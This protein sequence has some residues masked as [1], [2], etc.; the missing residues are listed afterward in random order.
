MGKNL[1][2]Q[3]RGKGGPR[4]R[5]PSFRFL[6]E[7]RYPGTLQTLN[8]KIISIEDCPGHS[9]PLVRVAYA[10][11]TEALQIAP[12]GIK[13]NDDLV[14]NAPEVKHGHVLKLGDVPEGT[15]VYNVENVPGDGGRFVRSSG[16]F[17]RIVAKTEL[18]VTL[19]LPSKKERLFNPRCRATVGIVAGGG[20]VE[21]PF[22]KAGNKHHAMV[23]RNRM[24]PQVKGQ[25]MNAVDHPHGGKRSSK[26]NA[27]TIARRHAP[28]G[29]KVGMLAPRRTGRRKL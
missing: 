28:P 20:R 14:L 23:A 17:A 15:L 7:P 18:N 26:K 6:G 10:D 8:G 12:E 5:S 2:Q 21:K 4:Y 9:A 16:T 1:I 27:P 3:A 22:V 13:I 24:W 19:L 11:G 25:S 29:A